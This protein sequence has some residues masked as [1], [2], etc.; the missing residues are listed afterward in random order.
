MAK[1]YCKTGFFTLIVFGILLMMPNNSGYAVEKRSYY[2]PLKKTGITVRKRESR[3]IKNTTEEE[4]FS[5]IRASLP[6]EGYYADVDYPE[7]GTMTL[8]KSK[9]VF[10]LKNAI[11]LGLI[12]GLFGNYPSIANNKDIFVTITTRTI[13]KN[14][15]SVLIQARFLKVKWGSGGKILSIGFVDNGFEISSFYYTL[16]KILGKT[17]AEIK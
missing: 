7:L 6:S 16:A 5:A 14:K 12:A 15:D 3:I 10:K 2:L 1:P 8:V 11:G 13:G 4:V 9:N 17:V